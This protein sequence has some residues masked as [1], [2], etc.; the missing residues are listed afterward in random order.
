M[1]KKIKT[2]NIN[3]IT[4]QNINP[5]I[6]EL[7]AAQNH[8]TKAYKIETHYNIKS[9]TKS[10]WNKNQHLIHQTSPIPSTKMV[11]TNCEIETNNHIKWSTQSSSL[12]APTVSKNK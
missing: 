12:F 5:L 3:H 11:D 6:L 2:C 4:K 1:G 9:F 8:S 7:I 10:T